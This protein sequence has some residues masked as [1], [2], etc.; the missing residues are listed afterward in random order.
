[1]TD[2]DLRPVDLSTEDAPDVLALYEGYGWWK[3][4]TVA[5]VERAIDHSLAVG[6]RAD[7]TGELVASARVVTDR[8]YYAW[9]HDVIVTAD[10]RGDALGERLMA[11]VVG[12]PDLADVAP[13]LVCRDGLVGFYERCGFERYPAAVEVPG[14]GREALHTLVYR[15]RGE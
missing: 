13:T 3:D 7:D 8:V 6:L 10:R 9:V 15:R 2:T 5:D 4:R 1:M 14:E 11:A 12:H